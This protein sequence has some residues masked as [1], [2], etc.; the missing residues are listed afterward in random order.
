[1]KKKKY[2]FLKKCKL[3]RT[4]VLNPWLYHLK[5]D[6]FDPL[7]R[8]Y[9]TFKHMHEKTIKHIPSQWHFSYI[10]SGDKAL[11]NSCLFPVPLIHVDTKNPSGSHNSVSSTFLFLRF[12]DSKHYQ[13]INQ[14]EITSLSGNLQHDLFCLLLRWGLHSSELC[15]GESQHGRKTGRRLAKKASLSWLLSEALPPLPQRVLPCYG[16]VH[17]EGRSVSSVENKQAILQRSEVSAIVVTEES[18]CWFSGITTHLACACSRSCYYGF[19]GAILFTGPF[20]PSE[21]HPYLVDRIL[22]CHRWLQRLF[23]WRKEEDWAHE[24]VLYWSRSVA[25]LLDK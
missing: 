11:F 13:A 6:R 20:S 17:K 22:S 2:G 4:L 12:I 14:E 25:H 23:H 7:G 18:P 9:L 10:I 5:F 15:G 19:K 8:G 16:A 21:E 24:A 3:Y 1:M